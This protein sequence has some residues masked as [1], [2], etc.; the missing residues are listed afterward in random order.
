MFH[1]HH[2]EKKSVGTTVVGE[3]GQIVIPQ[4]VRKQLN[5]KKGD[6]LL[7]FTKRN[8]FIG[9]L[10]TDDIDQVLDKITEKFTSTM[11]KIR[12]NV[13]EGK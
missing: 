5:L 11:E 7:V 12:K 1:D 9:L 3:R 4:E 6:K 10:K 2:F 13:K 8:K